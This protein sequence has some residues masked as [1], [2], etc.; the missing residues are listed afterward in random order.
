VLREAG[1]DERLEPAVVLHAFGERV[2]DHADVVA[3]VQL[4]L[5]RLLGARQ[6]GQRSEGEEAQ[7]DGP[8]AI[9]HERRL[10]SGFGGR[11]I[12]ASRARPV[13]LAAFLGPC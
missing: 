2:A 7:R 10:R 9:H 1:L 5:R 4:E 11:R 6:G 12:I 8:E 3:L 13:Q